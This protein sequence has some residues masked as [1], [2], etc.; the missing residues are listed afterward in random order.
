MVYVTEPPRYLGSY[1]E[2]GAIAP[3]A[4]TNWSGE[5]GRLAR[6]LGRPAQGISDV[7]GETPNTPGGT[8]AL[9]GIGCATPQNSMPFAVSRSFSAG[10][11]KSCSR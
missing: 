8:P 7:F 9:P 4:R 3:A 1:D 2:R 11:P 10:T 5:R 6:C